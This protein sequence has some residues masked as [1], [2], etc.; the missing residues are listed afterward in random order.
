MHPFSLNKITRH[1]VNTSV[2]SELPRSMVTTQGHADRNGKLPGTSCAEQSSKVQHPVCSHPRHFLA[3]ADLQVSFEALKTPD[4]PCL[5]LPLHLGDVFTIELRDHHSIACETWYQSLKH[6]FSSSSVLSSQHSIKQRAK[7][8]FLWCVGARVRRPQAPD[9][10]AG[11]G[12]NWWPGPL[13]I[14]EG[15]VL[16]W[17]HTQTT[18]CILPT[19][20]EPAR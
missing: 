10:L 17:R 9:F 16:D 12:A 18:W 15:R 7:L 3:T 5:H 14:R 11:W 13:L 2:L 19:R 20:K 1:T 8:R 6:L 4:P